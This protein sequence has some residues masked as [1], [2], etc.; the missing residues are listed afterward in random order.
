MSKDWKMAS[1]DVDYLADGVLD[2]YIEKDEVA[3][4]RLKDALDMFCEV[5]ERSRQ[6]IQRL[7]KLYA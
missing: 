3:R 4:L 5:E 6:E 2:G 7:Q 1:T